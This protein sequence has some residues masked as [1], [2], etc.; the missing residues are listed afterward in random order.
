MSIRYYFRLECGREDRMS[1]PIGPFDDFL[2]LT[3]TDLRVGPDG[4]EVA[5]F[6]RDGDWHLKDKE[7]GDPG[8]RW[9]DIVIWAEYHPDLPDPEKN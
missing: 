1:E 5:H 2:Q 8:E 7:F 9:S 4:K 3:Y 6:G